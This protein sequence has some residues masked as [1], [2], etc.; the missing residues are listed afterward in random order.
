MAGAHDEA[1]VFVHGADRAFV[2][3]AVMLAMAVAL[4]A[5]MRSAKRVHADAES[6]R[7]DEELASVLVSEQLVGD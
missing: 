5:S 4:V 1:A 6:E 7:L 2:V 3:A